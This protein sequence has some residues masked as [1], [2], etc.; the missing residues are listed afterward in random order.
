MIFMKGTPTHPMCLDSKKFMDV[1]SKHSYFMS[2][3]QYFDLLKDPEIAKSLY[4]YSNFGEMPQLY[5]DNKLIGG[6]EIIEAL[7]STG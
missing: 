5:I 1:L 3:V 4:Q 2:D 7:D 6:L